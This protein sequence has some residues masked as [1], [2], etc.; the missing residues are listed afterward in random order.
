MAPQGGAGNGHLV[1]WG[2]GSWQLKGW[3]LGGGAWS[4]QYAILMV[5]FQSFY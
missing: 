5:S 3:H 2:R 4:G 1:R